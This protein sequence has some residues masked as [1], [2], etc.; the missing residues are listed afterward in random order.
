MGS[1][2]AQSADCIHHPTKA[3]AAAGRGGRGSP[4]QE[5]GLGPRLITDQN[6]ATSKS[7][8]EHDCQQNGIP[9][10]PPGPQHWP[11][12]RR[13]PPVHCRGT[14]LGDPSTWRA[15]SLRCSPCLTHNQCKL[16]LLHSAPCQIRWQ[17][18]HPEP[19]LTGWAPWPVIPALQGALAGLP[20]A[21][22]QVAPLSCTARAS[23]A[24]ASGVPEPGP[25][26]PHALHGAAATSSC[27]PKPCLATPPALTHASPA[28]QH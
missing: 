27:L 2:A 12:V 4:L 26:W 5:A 24:R 10:E 22:C 16:F 7:S 14:L 15:T 17:S 9:Q 13:G 8:D 20:G 23:T 1:A 6:D 19:R 21:A 25:S 18:W 11:L 28:H 3:I